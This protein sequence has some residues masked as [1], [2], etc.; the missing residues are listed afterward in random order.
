MYS[1]E[2]QR[3]PD[4]EVDI[5]QE[6]SELSTFQTKCKQFKPQVIFAMLGDFL[7]RKTLE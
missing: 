3:F 4:I 1:R 2:L 5:Y 6:L 7:S